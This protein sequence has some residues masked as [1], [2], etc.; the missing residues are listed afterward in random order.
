[1]AYNKY[2]F[3]GR[4]GLEITKFYGEKGANGIVD[5]IKKLCNELQEPDIRLIKEILLSIKVG[6]INIF[7]FLYSSKGYINY[8]NSVTIKNLIEHKLDFISYKGFFKPSISDEALLNLNNA[9]HE[10]NH[11]ITILSKIVVESI[12][13]SLHVKQNNG[14]K[15]LNQNKELL[16]VCMKS[17]QTQNDINHLVK[18]IEKLMNLS[19]TKLGHELQNSLTLSQDVMNIM[20]LLD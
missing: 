17:I 16:E 13:K 5:K 9:Q 2:A 4:I 18:I 15:V 8:N 12:E 11:P 14:T 1:M 19:G 10:I 3:I 20:T 6:Q 7:S